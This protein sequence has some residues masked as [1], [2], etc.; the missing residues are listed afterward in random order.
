MAFRF[1]FLWLA[2]CLH[3]VENL[4]LAQ[5]NGEEAKPS[6]E[7]GAAP[8]CRNFVRNAVNEK[9]SVFHGPRFYA[10]W[11]YFIGVQ[12]KWKYEAINMHV[13]LKG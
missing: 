10:S 13:F 7:G 12:S 8:S 9:F 11:L 1:F 6:Q 2:I 3:I 4:F 5:Q